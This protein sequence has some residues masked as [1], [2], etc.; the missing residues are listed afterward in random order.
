MKSKMI[1]LAAA[2]AALMSAG[3]VDAQYY[4]TADVGDEDFGEPAR[5]MQRNLLGPVG[6]NLGGALNMP[7]GDS[8]SRLDPGGGF[9]AGISYNPL[10]AVGVQAEYM[11]S[12]ADVEDD[13]FQNAPRI[14]GNQT[15]QYGNLNVVVRPVRKNRFG[16]YILGGPGIYNRDVEVSRIDGVA[17]TTFCDPFLFVCSPA[18]V[19]VSTVVGSTDSTDFGVNGGVGVYAVLTPPLKMYLEARYH[20]IWGPTFT[21]AGG[22]E[23]NADGQYIPVV[24]GF[25][26]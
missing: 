6:I 8:G 19:P 25:A 14:D 4:S 15:M 22:E 17:T 9:T 24:L 26:F 18:A 1:A 10:P 12:Y 7:V 11:F 2:V 5:D 23:I 3:A 16:F 20:Y 13:V 21:P